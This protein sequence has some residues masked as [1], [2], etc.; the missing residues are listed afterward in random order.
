[1]IILLYSLYFT[2]ITISPIC[3]HLTNK[4]LTTAIPN[5]LV[6]IQPTTILVDHLHHQIPMVPITPV[7]A[8][9]EQVVLRLAMG[10]DISRDQAR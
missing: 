2:L 1:L 7:V 10:L 5:Q 9:Q 4:T 8:T 6:A 3:M